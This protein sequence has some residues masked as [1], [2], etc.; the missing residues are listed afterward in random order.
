MAYNT[1]A[2]CKKNLQQA[3]ERNDFLAIEYQVPQDV[4]EEI[5]ETQPITKLVL[6]GT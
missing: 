6:A 5:T 4:E 3:P 2:S 1:V